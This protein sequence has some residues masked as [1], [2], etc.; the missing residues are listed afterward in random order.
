MNL[1]QKKYCYEFHFWRL[2][3]V[4]KYYIIYKQNEPYKNSPGFIFRIG[5]PR[6]N[7]CWNKMLLYNQTEEILGPSAI[8][9]LLT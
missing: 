8:T 2:S 6:L 7:Q 1:I 3:Q 4:A 9:Y 5:G